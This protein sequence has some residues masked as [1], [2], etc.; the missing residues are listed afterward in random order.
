MNA[1]QIKFV[2]KVYSLGY[3]VF[4]LMLLVSCSTKKMN[5]PSSS[6]ENESR[7]I[8]TL[9]EHL[10]QKPGVFIQSGSVRIRGGDQSFFSDSDPLFEV[11]GQILTGG[12]Q[13][14][15]RLINPAEIKSVRV[16]KEPTDLAMYGARGLNGVIKIKLKNSTFERPY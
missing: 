16:L 10:L 13:E 7:E 12:Y 6:A 1:H 2:M 8:K 4:I 15:G 14:A 9:E 3:L 5:G 11:D